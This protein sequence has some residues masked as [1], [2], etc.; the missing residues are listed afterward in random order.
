MTGGAPI[1]VTVWNEG[2]HEETGQ[3][4]TMR[5]NYRDGIDGA[6]ATGLRE[7]LPTASVRTA[8]LSDVEHGLTTAVLATTDV[9]VWWGHLAHE[10]VDDEVVER[11]RDQVLAGMGLIVLHSGHLSK[12]FRALLGTSCTLL[13]RRE[14]ERELIWTVAP[15]HPIAEG[16]PNPIVLPQ[17][18]PYGEHF[19][20]PPPDELV[21][22]SSFD[23]GEVF[24]SGIT[25]QRGHGRVFYFG[26]GDQAYPVY[27]NPDVQ[28]VIANAVVWAMPAGPARHPPAVRHRKRGWF[29]AQT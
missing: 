29:T 23:G 4:A 20:V 28:R 5:T 21:F 8:R 10:A 6:I 19:D 7:R 17:Q 3:P 24:R 22:I 14:A 9:L 18:E 26:P 1:R 11:V 16:V 27:R 25:Y 2:I 15:S 13:W 12:P